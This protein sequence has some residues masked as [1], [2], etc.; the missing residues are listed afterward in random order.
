MKFVDIVP[1]H[2]D[3]DIK[4]KSYSYNFDSVSEVKPVAFG[5]ETGEVLICS[6]NSVNL[7]ISRIRYFGEPV[8]EIICCS[9]PD[10]PPSW[11]K[12]DVFKHQSEEPE[13]EKREKKYQPVMMTRALFFSSNEEIVSI[14]ISN[15]ETP[16]TINKIKIQ[17]KFFLK[18][19]GPDFMAIAS[20]NTVKV[21]FPDP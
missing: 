10:G 11:I 13:E 14:L 4:Q 19:L 12:A 21:V 20:S 6:C 3:S 15:Y 18:N 17:D 9:L 5:C 7:I 8:R 1:I 16:K 2:F